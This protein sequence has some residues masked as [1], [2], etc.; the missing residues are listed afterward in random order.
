MHHEGTLFSTCESPTPPLILFSS[1]FAHRNQKRSL[2]R[3]SPPCRLLH[4]RN[5]WPM[6]ITLIP[7]TS[8]PSVVPTLPLSSL[9]FIHIPSSLS[10][11]TLKTNAISSV[12]VQPCLSAPTVRIYLQTEGGLCGSFARHPGSFSGGI[13]TVCALCNCSGGECD[14]KT[15]KWNWRKRL[16]YFFF[17]LFLCE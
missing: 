1:Y 14:C 3:Q 8:R 7:V 17:F 6:A 2:G 4:C 16:F 10:R 11:S 5:P 9:L 12:T 13:K 15:G